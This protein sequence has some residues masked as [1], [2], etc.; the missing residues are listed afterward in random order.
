[1]PTLAQVQ[2]QIKSVPGLSV[3]LKSREVQELP[4]ILSDSEHIHDMVEGRSGGRKG[5]LISTNERLI[6]VDKGMLGRLRVEDFPNDKVT[7]IQHDSGWSTMVAKITVSVGGNEAEISHV[8]KKAAQVFC[9]GVRSRIS[10]GKA[11]ASGPGPVTAQSDMVTQLERLAKLRESGALTDEEFQ[12]QK[13]KILS[14]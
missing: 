7:S 11:A 14:A 3:F 5:I 2:S 10:A 1:M 8:P 6:F 9:Q 12:A 13:Q 4:G